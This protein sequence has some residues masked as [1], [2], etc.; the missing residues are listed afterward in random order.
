M[1]SIKD[2]AR[3]AGVSVGTV[4]NY[5]TGNKKVSPKVSHAIENAIKALG[6]HRNANAKNLRTG[7]TTEIGVLLPNVYSQYYSFLL[8]S[9]ETELRQSG[10]SINLGLTGDVPETEMK[11]LD[12]F[13]QKGVCGVISV[14][15]LD[16]EAHNKLPPQIPTVFIDREIRPGQSNFIGCDC[17]QTTLYL[18]EELKR[19][20]LERTA[21]FTGPLSFSCEQDSARAYRDFC[22]RT[23]DRHAQEDLVSVRLTKEEGF[24]A[25]VEYLQSHRP[26]AIISTS[27]DLTNGLE[28]ALSLLGISTQSGIRVISFGQ[29]NWSKSTTSN[30]ILHTMRPAHLMGKKAASLLIDNIKSPFLFEKQQI[31]FPD[32]IIEHPLDEG[33]SV[34]CSAKPQK[35]LRI[36]MLDSP[37]AHAAIQTRSDFTRGSGINAD[38]TLCAHDALLSRLLSPE[39][40]LTGYDIVMYDNPWLDTLVAGGRLSDMTE[41]AREARLPLDSFLPS[42]VEKIGVV[43]GQ[44]YGIPFLFGPQLLLYRK[45]LF[46]DERLQERFEKKYHTRLRPPRS[47]FEFNVQCGFFTRALNGD[48]PTEYGT[49]IAAQNQS[50]LM[51]ELL[52]R[53]WAYGGAVFDAHGH[54]ATH[55]PAF[56][57]G[58]ASF[59]DAVKSASPGTANYAVEQTV[60]D[61]HQG[62]AAMLVSFASFVADV[63]NFRKSKI[64]GKIGYSTIPGGV[65][66]FSGW[67]L[68]VTAASA[69]KTEALSFIR[70]I[71]DPQVSNYFAIL[72]GQSALMSAYVNDELISH[73]PWLPII[74]QSYQNNRRRI[75]PM[76]KD[77]SIVSITEVERLIYQCTMEILGEKVTINTALMKLTDNIE[78]LLNAPG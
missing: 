4:S 52:P 53:V 40:D 23:G 11:I 39:S 71:C 43:R 62:K 5:L 76:R 48:S 14:S 10:Y 59:L 65:S 78:A 16:Q 2:V 28:Q 69:Q 31:V 74:H 66:I 18:L 34:P 58:V 33:A 44:L 30:G 72:D 73:Y 77:G 67:G 64:I 12:L 27:R 24:R 75:A 54:A 3:D 29:E 45:D 1:P 36:L 13:A 22:A 49:A 8:A 42:L 51:P 15:C 61:F 46:E 38:I 9:M 17:Y 60:A 41:L 63:N 56:Q 47:W 6:Y 20:G 21:L 55:T 70:W 32:K 50:V 68:G 19:L 35:T 57:K 25:C 7:N 37:S 26:D